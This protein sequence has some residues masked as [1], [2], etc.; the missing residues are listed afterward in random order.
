MKQI[1]LPTAL[2]LIAIL[3]ASLAFVIVARV[4]MYHSFLFTSAVVVLIMWRQKISFNG[5]VQ[6]ARDDLKKMI[7]VMYVLGSIGMMIAAWMYSGVLAAC[8]DLG[9]SI[10]P[11]FNLLLSSFLL[12][13]ILSMLLGTAVGTIG[14]LGTML[15]ILGQS[16]DIPLP[17]VAGAIISGSYFGDRT[18][19]M[20]SSANL[21]ASIIGIDLNQHVKILLKTSLLPIIISIVFYHFLGAPYL[22]DD[23]MFSLIAAKR[24]V[25]KQTFGLQLYHFIPVI[26]LLALIV[27]AKKGIVFAV[28]SSLT[29]SLLLVVIEGRETVLFLKTI[30][31]GYQPISPQIGEI[32]QGSGL[33]SMLSIFI[34]LSSAS[35]L[36]TL[37]NHIGLFQPLFGRYDK[38]LR[39]DKQLIVGAGLAAAVVMLLTGNQSLPIIVSADHYLAEFNKRNIKK[40]WLSQSVSDY[41]LILVALPP[42]NINALLVYSLIGVSSLAYAPYAILPLAMP[43]C[44]LLY[45]QLTKSAH[46]YAP[47]GQSI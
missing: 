41:M 22:A 15:M 44:S 43:L 16:L 2:L 42:W 27:V 1:N 14:T 7:P 17:L 35:L 46:L 11:H 10:L 47:Q 28:I 18:S 40:S 32:F 12:T 29:S 4:A 19:P 8:M 33:I 23:A 39:G 3:I 30:I 24:L 31:A 34:V 37:F 20:S 36:N 45:M 5:V 21:T 38:W 13:L 26:I 6:K 9:L 25:L